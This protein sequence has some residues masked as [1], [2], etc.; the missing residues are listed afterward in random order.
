M[1]CLEV[2]DRLAEHAL[3]VLGPEE[4]RDVERHLDWCAGC[5]KE[6]EEL[7]EGLVSVAMS[8]P[9]AEPPSSLEERVVGRVTSAAGTRKTR[10]R[11]ISPRSLVAASLMAVLLAV[12]AVG[13]G[14]AERKRAGDRDRVLEQTRNDLQALAAVIEAQRRALAGTGKTLEADLTL[15]PNTSRLSVGSAL[16]L[17]APNVEDFMFVSVVGPLRADEGP[18]EVRILGP[19]G[20]TIYAGALSPEPDGDHRFAKYVDADLSSAISLVVVDREGRPRVRGV[21]KHYTTG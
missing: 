1:T 3:G 9:A 8:L 2:R 10:R 18:F 11:R 5:R 21:L 6:S 14:F 15:S 17:V 4:S 19:D 7:Q 20:V 12:G 16:V 13:W